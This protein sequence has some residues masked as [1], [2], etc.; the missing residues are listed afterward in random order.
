M[1]SPEGEKIMTNYQND[2][3][4]AIRPVKLRWQEIQQEGGIY[5]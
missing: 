5:V 3:D 1:N 4:K 2:I